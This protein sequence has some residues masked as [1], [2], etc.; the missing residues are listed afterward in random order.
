MGGVTHSTVV[1]VPDDP[2]YPVGS[3]EWNAGHTITLTASDVGADAAGAA[4]AAQAASW[5][6]T[7]PFDATAPAAVGTAAAGAAATASHRDH[8]HP[9]GAGTPSTQ[10]FG[11]S[12]S[13]GTGPAASM[14]DHKHAMPANPV[15]YA[16]PS[17]TLGT[18]NAAG[19]AASAVR[20]DATILAFDAT[21]PAAVGTAAVGAATVAARRDHVHATG[22]GTPSTQAFGDSPSTGTGPAAAMTDHKHGMP[23]VGT[24]ASQ[25]ANNVTITGGSVT[26]ITDLTV[27]DGG[28]GASTA[29]AA[30]NN[31][32]RFFAA[33][34]SAPAI[35]N[36]ETVICSV[37]IPAARFQVGSAIRFT[38]YAT[39]NN[40]ASAAYV[41]RIR[42]GTS[43]LTGAIVM[44]Q[45]HTIAIATRNLAFTGLATVRTT[46]SS[47]TAGGIG[48]DA[49]SWVSGA[50]GNMGRGALTTP[51]TVDT[52][53]QNLVELTFISG[54]ASNTYTF[55]HALLEV[56]L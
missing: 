22:A 42:V 33:P 53:V 51:V 3:D 11:D 37:T 6:A 55:E 4:A 36:T 17:L 38:L 39:Y 26:G 52:T 56:L 14:T 50:D 34:T 45:T 21:T 10:A 28:T 1:V 15:A 16:A 41:A 32:G 20:T 2:A 19:S 18:A 44:S 25:N 40:G 8:V 24:I 13:T 27:A 30:L 9:T 12:A 54:S 23:S 35:A 43:T 48:L 49:F 7:S 47:G 46:G 29:A 5:P 31:L